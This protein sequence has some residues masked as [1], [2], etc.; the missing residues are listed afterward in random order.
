MK[1]L[2]C[3]F[4]DGEALEKHSHSHNAVT[5]GTCLASVPQ[6]GLGYGD[7]GKYWNRRAA[8]S[9][10]S[11]GQWMPIET[12]PKD[13][14]WVHITSPHWGFSIVA[15]W[16][17]YPGNPAIA[18]DGSDVW[19]YGWVFRDEYLTFGGVEDGFL[20]WDEDAMPQLW[21]PPPPQGD[22]T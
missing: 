10:P 14:T 5:C 19:M 11:T 20:G 9:H 12:C 7:A 3:P 15:K 6:S 18:A 17:E 16:A 4:C 2:P 8:L 22:K 21:C 1:L 13:G